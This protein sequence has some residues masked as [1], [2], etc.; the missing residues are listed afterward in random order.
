MNTELRKELL[1]AKE[2]YDMIDFQDY[3]D[4]YMLKIKKGIYRPEDKRS[5]NGDS[6][7]FKKEV[8]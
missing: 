7:R 8:N 6:S 5:S 1:T 3:I 2:D 4:L